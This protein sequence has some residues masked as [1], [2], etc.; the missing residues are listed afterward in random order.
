MIWESA[1]IETMQDDTDDKEQLYAN[2]KAFLQRTRDEA[3]RL[4][5]EIADA[6]IRLQGSHEARELA[7]LKARLENWRDAIAALSGELVRARRRPARDWGQAPTVGA[8]NPPARV[9]G[10]IAPHV[11][12]QGPPVSDPDDTPPAA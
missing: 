6:E 11:A 8:P 10:S 3:A 4:E 2:A 7:R 5:R 12:Q 1:G 9:V